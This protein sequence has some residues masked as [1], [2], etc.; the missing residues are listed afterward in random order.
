MRGPGAVG[1]NVPTPVVRA[2][3][4]EKPM[5]LVFVRGCGT[6]ADGAVGIGAD[7]VLLSA[8]DEIEVAASDDYDVRYTLNPIDSPSSDLVSADSAFVVAVPKDGCHLLT[9]DL[10]GGA[11][12]AR[13]AAR[14]AS[15]EDACIKT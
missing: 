8:A 11:V 10:D 3:D 15:T 4:A 1:L 5:D 12:K 6:E 9:A 7:A 2:G 14:V 13:Y